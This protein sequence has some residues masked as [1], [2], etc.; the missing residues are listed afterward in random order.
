MKLGSH[1]QE[2]GDCTFYVWA[3]HVQNIEL[4]LIDHEQRYW[5]MMAEGNG[6]YYLRLPNIQPGNRYL[7]RLDGEGKYPDPSSRF[8]PESV[9]GASQVI[10]TSFVWSDRAWKNP[11]LKD[12][13]FYE[14]HVGT[15]TQEGTFD[16]IIPYLDALKDLGITNLELMPIAQFPGGRN[17]GYDGVQLYAVQNTYGGP[18]GLKRLVNACHQH[19]IAV[20][21][22]VVYNHLGPEGNYLGKYGPYFTHRYQSPWGESLNLDGPHSDEVRRFLIENAIYWLEDFHIDAFRL[23]ATHALLD[24]S[25]IPFIRQLVG[26][27]H[28]WAADNQKNIHLIAE[29]DRSDVRL[30]RPP[31]FG[32]VGL[33]AQWLDDLHHCVH[34]LLTGE[35]EGYYADYY[36][37]QQLVK[38]LD[39]GFVYSGEYSPVRRRRHG[40][41]SRGVPGDRFVVSMQNHDQ[42]GNRM[43]GERL[44]AL[45]DFE[46]LKLAAGINIL[47]KYVPML[48]MGE[49]YAETAPFLYFISH[50]DAN[51]IEATRMGRKAEFASFT[52]KGEPPDPMDEETFERCK[53]HHDLYNQDSHRTLHEFYKTLLH[54]R[55]TIPALNNPISEDT[56][57]WGDNLRRVLFMQR[58]GG[59]SE[60]FMIFNMHT[61]QTATLI[62]PFPTG[63]WS[64]LLASTDKQWRAS[65]A[66]P[67]IEQKKGAPEWVLPPKSF[68]LFTKR[69]P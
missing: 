26:T 33:D 61:E 16:A 50:S 12:Q 1:L 35:Q 59:D 31:E 66:A 69:E 54:I 39:E 8:Q 22:D 14:L 48:F 29:N 13:V 3:P 18:D 55:K 28:Q 9:H 11:P 49:E 36:D 57:V 45:T 63:E 53:L 40:T 23:D 15:F 62:P 51:L 7:Y 19:G 5:P 24:F 34:H 30:V 47:S 56:S 38:A 52:W 25:A 60:V 58:K 68:I 32:G 64:K 4:C 44:T 67:E 41:S 20:T 42:I 21:L 37:F 65:T 43:L 27:V 6:Y 10:D 17:W 2:N 46:G